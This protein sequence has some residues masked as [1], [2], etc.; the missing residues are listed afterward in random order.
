MFGMSKPFLAAV[1]I[2]LAADSAAFACGRRWAT[3]PD[4]YA[5]DNGF[6]HS[7]Y[8]DWRGLVGSPS[9]KRR[10]SRRQEHVYTD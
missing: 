4:C 7:L 1:A 6:Y 3:G 5:D 8:D 10:P 9:Q 2:F